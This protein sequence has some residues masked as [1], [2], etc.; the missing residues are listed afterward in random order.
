MIT[1]QLAALFSQIAEIECWDMEDG[2][3]IEGVQAVISQAGSGFYTIAGSITLVFI[4]LASVPK[5]TFKWSIFNDIILRRLIFFMG[6]GSSVY[7]LLTAWVTAMS[8]CSM[9]DDGDVALEVFASMATT[10]YYIAMAIYPLT[11][12]LVAFVFDKFLHRRKL[13]SIFRSNNKIFGLI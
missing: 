9:R 13:M 7:T 4:L 1:E 11:F 2:A 8:L 3:C 5:Y 10:S 12:I 6:L